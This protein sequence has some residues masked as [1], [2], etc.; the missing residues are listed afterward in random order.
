MDNKSFYI[1]SFTIVRKKS[2]TISTVLSMT[3]LKVAFRIS[4]MGSI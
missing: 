3:L 2:A 1:L 4:L